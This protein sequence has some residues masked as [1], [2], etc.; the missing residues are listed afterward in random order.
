MIILLYYWLLGWP[1]AAP[2]FGIL[3]VLAKDQDLQTTALLTVAVGTWAWMVFELI[4]S[5]ALTVTIIVYG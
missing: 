3:G 1:V 4:L 5:Q 2:V